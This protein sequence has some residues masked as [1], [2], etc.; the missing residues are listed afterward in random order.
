MRRAAPAAL[1]GWA[2]VALLG[3]GGA[4]AGPPQYLPIEAEWCLEAAPGPAVPPRC[5]QLEVP[6]TPQQQG[7]GMMLRPPL[8]PLRGMWFPFTPPQTVSFWMHRTIAPLDM[9]FVREGRVIAIEAA[10]IP[11]PRLPC[12]GYGPAEPVDG[13]VELDAGEAERLGIRPGSPAPIRLK[14]A[15]P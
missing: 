5:I 4:K 9:V 3:G 1:L 6:R 14:R 2:A 15:A 12:R 11:C 7:W 13:V 10:A 8:G